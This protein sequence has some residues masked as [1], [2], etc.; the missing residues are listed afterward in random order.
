MDKENIN[1]HLRC[2]ELAISTIGPLSDYRK[3]RVL[4]EKTPVTGYSF[5]MLRWLI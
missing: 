2:L 5:S 3:A 4:D 1:F